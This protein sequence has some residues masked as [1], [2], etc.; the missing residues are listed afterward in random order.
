MRSTHVSISTPLHRNITKTAWLGAD[1]AARF[2]SIMFRLWRSKRKNDMSSERRQDIFARTMQNSKDTA[3]NSLTSNNVH[4]ILVF[5]WNFLHS[6]SSNC[7]WD[8]VILWVK[9]LVRPGK[10]LV[11]PTQLCSSQP[12]LIGYVFLGISQA[13][14][15]IKKTLMLDYFLHENSTLNRGALTLLIGGGPELSLLCRGESFVIAFSKS[16][17][18]GANELFRRKAKM[19]LLLD[20]YTKSHMAF[21]FY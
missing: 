16:S 10:R 9:T 5:L 17:C 19:P 8:H 1:A 20:R 4:K 7:Y 12:K 2:L 6:G 21:R 13:E 15:A 11:F 3:Q 18:A 14:E